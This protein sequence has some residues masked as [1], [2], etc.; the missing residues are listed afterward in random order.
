MWE[1]LVFHRIRLPRRVARV[2]TAIGIS[3]ALACGFVSPASAGVGYTCGV[4]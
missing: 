1:D 2:V 3:V 4:S